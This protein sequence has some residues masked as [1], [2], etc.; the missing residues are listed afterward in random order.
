MA[1]STGIQPKGLW[2]IFQQ[3][4]AALSRWIQ[5]ILTSL[6]NWIFA[7]NQNGAS[8]RMNL[9]IAITLLL[10]VILA[11]FAHPIRAGRDPVLLQFLNALFSPD[12]IRHFVV[13]LLALWVGFRM[14][15]IYLS[16]IFELRNVRTAED[17]IKRAVFPGQYSV[18]SIR[19]AMVAPEDQDSFLNKIGGPGFVNVHLENVALFEKVDGTPHVIEPSRT[20][21]ELLEGF[22]RYREAIDLR[23]QVLELDVVEGRTLD[24]IPVWAKDVR[25]VYSIYRG[26]AKKGEGDSYDQPYPF[27]EK[28]VE[29]L[30]YEGTGSWTKTMRSLIIDDLRKFIASH[31]LSEF[32][33]NAYASSG[34]KEF[35]ARD[36]ITSRFY[37]ELTPQASKRGVQLDWIGVGTWVTH[38]DIIPSQHLDAWRLSSETRSLENT[39]NVNRNYND[40]RQAKLLQLIDDILAHYYQQQNSDQ[41][42]KPRTIM[43][44]LAQLYREKLRHVQA[45][46]VDANLPPQTEVEEAIQHITSVTAVQPGKRPGG[47]NE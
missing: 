11:L 20:K 32:F 31:K 40:S 19:D 42:I 25:L 17:F 1:K 33:T 39:L 37:E 3:D 47:G 14:A 44:N 35:V 29:T 16:D 46:Y 23:D 10:W 2:G 26:E 38:S 9:F 34:E 22:E 13:L 12:V 6:A 5:D 27:E 4:L 41:N 18:I 21:M 30:I 24:G 43:R 36:K 28:A 8:R 7:F 45:L 15:A